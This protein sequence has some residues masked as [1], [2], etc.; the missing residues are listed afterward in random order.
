MSDPIPKSSKKKKPGAHHKEYSRDV[1]PLLSRRPNAL[2]EANESAW[3]DREASQSHGRANEPPPIWHHSFNRYG[4]IGMNLILFAGGACITGTL[5][6][7]HTFFLVL[8]WSLFASGIVLAFVLLLHGLYGIIMLTLHQQ[9]TIAP[10]TLSAV[11]VAAA[12]VSSVTL[13]MITWN[14]LTDT[15][16]RDSLSGSFLSQQWVVAVDDGGSRQFDLCSLERD[17]SCRGW[18]EG[19]SAV[20]MSM[21]DD[22]SFVPSVGYNDSAQLLSLIDSLGNL[23]QLG[24]C[25]VCN[26]HTNTTKSCGAAIAEIVETSLWFVLGIGFTIVCMV[27][28]N[29]VW[30]AQSSAYKRRARLTSDLLDAQRY[31]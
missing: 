22:E 29:A 10:Y 12:V 8:W 23:T 2:N 14:D 30:A 5:L 11:A 9:P 3:E 6:F 18:H 28:L 13:F 1:S 31:L 17:L 7:Y 27:S 20:H 15:T 21:G 24:N 4:L 19:C 16:S 25:P 26:S